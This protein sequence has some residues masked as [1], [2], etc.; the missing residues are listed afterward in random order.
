TGASR[1]DCR[2]SAT[3]AP[4]PVAG[5][6][7]SAQS[8]MRNSGAS[9]SCS[10]APSPIAASTWR[11]R[12]SRVASIA[13][14]GESTRQPPGRT[15]MSTRKSQRPFATSSPSASRT[16]A[17][18]AGAMRSTI[19]RAS[20]STSAIASLNGGRTASG[21]VSTCVRTTWAAICSDSPSIR[22][23]SDSSS[24]ASDWSKSVTIASTRC[25]SEP[26][27]ARSSSSRARA[28]S[29]S[30]SS[31]PCR[32]PSSKAAARTASSDSCGV[33]TAADEAGI[34]ASRPRTARRNGRTEPSRSAA[35]IRLD[36]GFRAGTDRHLSFVDE[37][38]DRLQDLALLG[39]DLGE[40]H[41]ALRL[42][43]LAQRLGGARAHVAEDLLA[44]LGFRSLQCDDERIALDF[45]EQGLD[46]PVVHLQQV[47]EG[48][49]LVH[50]LLGDVRVLVADPLEHLGV[51]AAA[52]EVQDL[53]GRLGAAQ[54]RALQPV[55]PAQQLAEDFVEFAQGCRLY[56]LER[57][58]AIHD[59][60]PHAFGQVLQYLGRMVAL[61]MHDDGRHDL[62][63]LVA[64]ELRNGGCVHPLEAFDARDIA[65]LQD[66]V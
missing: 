55:G 1:R 21:R 19:R 59:V 22:L 8:S 53:G 48:E 66:A 58:D 10:G 33:S 52:Q 14:I 47:L 50:D 32:R 46:A 43:V 61:E 42:E 27:L 7:R 18:S 3:S 20:A 56:A 29:A 35:M 16:T 44:Q 6:R 36:I 63:M 40:L 11:Q 26:A 54:L 17:S 31:R 15:D 38:A 49:H 65:A 9:P 51:G 62:G 23:A 5:A 30:P 13:A 45:P 4:H 12:V 60:R 39:L 2:T 64:Y 34:A 25:A 37:A 41:R 57:R 24:A 28:A